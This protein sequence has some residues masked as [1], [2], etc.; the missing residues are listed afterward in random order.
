MIKEREDTVLFGGVEEERPVNSRVSEPGNPI[1]GGRIKGNSS[2][3][4]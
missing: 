3:G 4:E 1:T 2:I